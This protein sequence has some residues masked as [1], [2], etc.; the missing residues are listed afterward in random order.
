MTFVEE[1]L[2]RDYPNM[3]AP[4]KPGVLKSLSLKIVHANEVIQG[5]GSP[6]SKKQSSRNGSELVG[7]KSCDIS[8]LSF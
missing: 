8:T 6:S 5:R 3:I 4:P 1:W 2:E 7:F